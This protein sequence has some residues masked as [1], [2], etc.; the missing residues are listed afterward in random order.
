M[1]EFGEMLILFKCERH[2]V[3]NYAYSEK[4]ISL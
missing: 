2:F 3:N 4:I 1:P